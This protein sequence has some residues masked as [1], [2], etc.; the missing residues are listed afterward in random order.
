MS[1]SI[2]IDLT[3]QLSILEL[4]PPTS[5]IGVEEPCFISHPPAR[6]GVRTSDTTLKSLLLLLI[7]PIRFDNKLQKCYDFCVLSDVINKRMTKK[8][9]YPREQK[10]D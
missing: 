4:P 7:T 5:S 8:V 2:R 10:G 9:N 6:I 3:L 1:T